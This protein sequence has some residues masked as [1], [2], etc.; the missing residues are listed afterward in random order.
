MSKK[1]KLLSIIVTAATFA[2][3]IVAI[4]TYCIKFWNNKI[5]SDTSDFGVFGDY[6]GGVIGTI[7]AIYGAFYVYKTYIQQK[8]L[9]IKQ[10]FESVFFQ[11]LGQQRDIVRNLKGKI[12]QTE[13]QGYEY[14]KALHEE[15]KVPMDD[16]EILTISE[17]N[18]RYKVNDFYTEIFG[19]HISQLGHY[20]RHLYHIIKYVDGSHIDDDSKKDYIDFIQA[21]MTTDELYLV[22]LNGVS[23]YGYKKA[24][25]LIDKY[26]LVENIA[27]EKDD[28]ISHIIETFYKKTQMKNVI[29]KGEDIIFI[30]GVH[31]S[32]KTFFV[33]NMP[34][35]FKKKINV[36]TCSEVLQW[37]GD[38]KQVDDASEN[39]KRLIFNLRELIADEKKYFLVGHFCLINM[40]K[41]IERLPI[42]TFRAI[43]PRSLI[44]IETDALTIYERLKKRKG[45]DPWDISLV[46]KFIKEEREHA[47]RISNELGIELKI[48][49]SDSYTLFE[50]DFKEF[51]YPA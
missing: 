33:D 30:G 12:G 9:G 42:D 41:K 43:N 11:L 38:S 40:S 34:R 27:I 2:L 1:S 36:L 37:K 19:E 22:V 6:V 25:P 20:F 44:L 51:I 16:P 47:T 35:K 3:I 46:E 45:S 48:Y 10:Q 26:S 39:Q 7:V 31:C 29:Q 13:Y 15:L 50:S 4:C 28:H 8:E 21:Q 32:G 24:L 17:N 23:E 14:L 18:L 5:S 49:N